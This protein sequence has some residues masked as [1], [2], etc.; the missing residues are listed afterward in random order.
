M[1]NYLIILIIG[2]FL[3]SCGSG[4]SNKTPSVQVFEYQLSNSQT[5]EAKTLPL[6]I[7]KLKKIKLTDEQKKF[8]EFVAK[9][10]KTSLNIKKPLIDFESYE[11]KLVAPGEIEI[12][13]KIVGDFYIQNKTSLATE[14][15]ERIYGV[16]TDK[17]N[18]V[19]TLSFT[20]KGET[21]K[22][23]VSKYSPDLKLVWNKV[24]GFDIV[25]ANSNGYLD[26]PSFVLENNFLLVGITTKKTLKAHDN[27]SFDTKI[28]GLARL[29]LN[30]KIEY[31]KLFEN[32]N[33]AT[34]ITEYE[35]KIA[36]YNNQKNSTLEPKGVALSDAKK[37][38]IQKQ[39]ALDS[40]QQNI[41]TT[42]IE[43]DHNYTTMKVVTQYALETYNNQTQ[44]IQ[45]K[46]LNKPQGIL[47]GLD[48]LKL[49]KQTKDEID[50]FILNFYKLCSQMAINLPVG[51]TE[52][53][54]FLKI[55][56]A[57]K[58]ASKA[59]TFRTIDIKD[60]ALS[61]RGDVA[62]ELT[63]KFLIDNAGIKQAKQELEN[64]KLVQTQAQ[65][66]YDDADKDI[67]QLL[68]PLNN[69]KNNINGSF[70]LINAIAVNKNEIIV[71]FGKK[72]SETG[73]IENTIQP[74]DLDGNL[75]DAEK[76][77]NAPYIT[78][79]IKEDN[80]IY[81]LARSSQSGGVKV[82]TIN[83]FIGT[84]KEADEL[85]VKVKEST[86]NGLN[87]FYP[88]VVADDEFLYVAI[89]GDEKLT[90]NGAVKSEP[91]AT[92]ISPFVLKVK[93]QDLSLVKAVNIASTGAFYATG[94]VLKN[95]KLFLTG[96]SK[97][98]VGS[99]SPKGNSDIVLLTLNK[100]L[101]MQKQIMQGS[102]DKTNNTNTSQDISRAIA[103]DSEENVI[104]VGDTQGSIGGTFKGGFDGFILK[105]KETN[106]NK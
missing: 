96:H 46:I 82:L 59:Y 84:N 1:K 23:S 47:N 24:L 60:F 76:I 102:L 61:K 49:G 45:A 9:G 40:A 101:A 22:A 6:S 69:L 87:D 5:G 91:K 52:K 33:L 41:V 65:T 11:T 38:V 27:T 20:T 4:E 92:S 95:D 88:K 16:Q 35:T 89:Q 44:E 99:Y 73:S 48:D 29:D 66:A 106:E 83:K 63:N 51:T 79:F 39:Q 74:I 2:I 103:V 7:E 19:Y 81:S 100:D 57:L 37:L 53:T 50:E 75:V 14:Q 42:S 86:V 90:V 17:E 97:G 10:D 21:T 30:G 34:Y 18:N 32:P 104:L 43:A 105:L 56:N 71:S 12:T 77:S 72:T 98:K 25:S 85:V 3:A 55:F 68:T 26:M 31:Q 54:E 36:E 78:A 13:I 15:I 67:K 94:L 62:Q 64:A 58:K 70:S 28:A 80:T 93:K 8:F